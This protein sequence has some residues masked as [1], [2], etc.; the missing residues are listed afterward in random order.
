MAWKPGLRPAWPDA[1][2]GASIGVHEPAAI[3]AALR[4]LMSTLPGVGKAGL[5]LSG[6]MDSA[7]LAALMP[8]GAP[9]YTIRFVADGAE[10]E[11]PMAARYAQRYG[12]AHHVVD[13]TWADF[14]ATMDGLMRRKRSPLHA[15]EVGLYLAARRA[16]ADGVQTLVLGNGA[17]STFGGLDKLLSRDW[18]NEAF[19]A[20]YT[21]L[22]PRCVLRQPIDLRA[23]YAPYCRDEFF[24]VVPFL[25]VVHG[26]GIIQ[27]FDNALGAAGC[28]AFEPYE[29][30]CLDAPLDLARIRRGESKYLLR[31]VFA[32]LYPGLEIPP[33]IAFARP[34]DIWLRDWAGPSRPEFLPRLDMAALSGEQRWLLYC[35]ERFLNL[36]D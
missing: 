22:D 4:A 14:E 10:D 34:M 19:I 20:R 5:L 9:A 24:D 1:G 25:K 13:V 16:L 17:D 23:V 26:T 30:L 12:L 27:A 18:P 33:K 35:L 7:I 32:Q 2:P 6:G 31:E 28:Q 8:P 11:S 29:R 15:V 36:M 21:F 3:L